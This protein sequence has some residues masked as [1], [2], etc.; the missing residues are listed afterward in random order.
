LIDQ[1][2]TLPLQAG[3]LF[4]ELDA[5]GSGTLTQDELGLAGSLKGVWDRFKKAPKARGDGSSSSSSS[6]SASS[7]S[8]SSASGRSSGGEAAAVKSPLA[9]QQTATA[10]DATDVRK[11]DARK[12]D[13]RKA[14]GPSGETKAKQPSAKQL[15]DML[16]G[17]HDGSLT[18]NEVRKK[19]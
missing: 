3:K 10:G 13:A 12:A 15:F 9:G 6:S 19:S 11:A 5:D 8:S 18:R 16:D 1:P 17:D 7:S 4:D 14:D 2:Q